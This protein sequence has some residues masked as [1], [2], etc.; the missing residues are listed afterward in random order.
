MSNCAKYRRLWQINLVW[1]YLL[2]NVSGMSQPTRLKEFTRKLPIMWNLL[3]DFIDPSA[4]K[5]LSVAFLL[6]QLPF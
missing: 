2:T 4:F 3:C 5:C 6:S 1:I